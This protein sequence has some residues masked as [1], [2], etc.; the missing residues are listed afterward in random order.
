MPIQINKLTGQVMLVSGLPVKTSELVNDGMPD[1][2]TFAQGKGPV[3]I[4][5]AD[6][7]AR[8]LVTENGAI[9]T[10]DEGA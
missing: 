8:R 9:G 6:A 1:D 10:E 7:G 4:D 5:K 3:I 2:L